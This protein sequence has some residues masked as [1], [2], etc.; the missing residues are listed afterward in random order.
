MNAE[1]FVG[2]LKE[3]SR[4]Y[5]LTYQEIKSLLLEYPY[6]SNLHQMLA[7]KAQ[8]EDHKEADKLLKQAAFYS[9]NRSFLYQLMDNLPV[10]ESRSANYVITE[11]YL[12][13]SDLSSGGRP[14]EEPADTPSKASE[15][16]A[17]HWPEQDFN[18]AEIEDISFEI[19]MDAP[20]SSVVDESVAPIAIELDA[21]PPDKPSKPS[22]KSRIF[23]IE[24][25]ISDMDASLELTPT[26]QDQPFEDKIEESV[27]EVEEAQ[28][29]PEE[30]EA[31]IAPRYDVPLEIV[32]TPTDELEWPE[33]NNTAKEPLKTTELT[34]D[35]AAENPS[36][37]TM[38]SEEDLSAEE[39]VAPPAPQPKTSFS[40]WLKRYPSP[41][42]SI[43]NVPPP[44][45]PAAPTPFE[46]KAAKKKRDQYTIEDLS[47]AKSKRSTSAPKSPKVGKKKKTRSL[48]NRSLEENAE[49]VSETLAEILAR[50]GSYEKAVDMYRRLSL[51]FPEKSTFFA[52]RITELKKLY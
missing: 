44:S 4:L 36:P 24:D 23:F 16:E 46:R 20:E 29:L 48:A 12:E 32:N 38:A 8:M 39:H 18:D 49:I 5:Q 50:Q 27:D 26:W 21:M 28:Q 33:G 47:E 43:Q 13:L 31:T 41:K 34:D 11:D 51:I 25:L 52:K 2:F 42:H 17:E 19:P 15:E 7:I 6:C 45:T 1:S 35:S 37:M 14:V 22:D 10:R 40:S 3:P 9:P 30:T